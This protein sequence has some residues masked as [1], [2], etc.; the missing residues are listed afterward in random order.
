MFSKKIVYTAGTWDLLHI[1]HIRLL[2]RCKTFG[3]TLIVGVSTDEVVKSHKYKNPFNS[4]D[5][6]FEMVSS[7]RAVD[8]TVKQS[9]L[10]DIKFMLTLNIDTLVLG[11]D[12]SSSTLIGIEWAR[13]EKHLIFLPRT[14]GI[15]TSL[16]KQ[17][18]KDL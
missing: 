5:V 4:Y 2:N 15:S 8:L 7:L 10:L 9:L 18:L 1:G 6:R 12:W 13:R 16:I 3:D 14:E 17:R 11:D